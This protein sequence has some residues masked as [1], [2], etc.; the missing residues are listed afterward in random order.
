M[1]GSGKKNHLLVFIVD[2][3]ARED[4]VLATKATQTK[5]YINIDT[6]FIDSV[7]HGALLGGSFAVIPLIGLTTLAGILIHEIHHEIG[8][9]A[10]L[11]RSGFDLWQATKA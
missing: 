11:L 4:V 1:F 2:A 8:D 9:F 10:I 7:T 3:L 5:Y 6:N